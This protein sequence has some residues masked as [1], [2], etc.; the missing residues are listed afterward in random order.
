MI[1]FI[2]DNQQGLDPKQSLSVNIKFGK[3]KQ[4]IIHKYDLV[5]DFVPICHACSLLALSYL[6][7][8]KQVTRKPLLFIVRHDQKQVQTSTQNTLAMTE[9]LDSLEH[10]LACQVCFH[11]FDEDGEHIPR[12]LPCS[13]TL[14][15]SCIKQLIQNSKLE[16]PECRKIHDAE[17]VKTFP[18]NKYILTQL[19]RK[20]P[21]EGSPPK[22]ELCE[23]HKSE[24]ILFCLEGTCQKAICI[25]C[26]NEKHRRHD[27]T[28]IECGQKE[29]QAKTFSIVERNLKNKIAVLSAAKNDVEKK[30]ET[31]KLDLKKRKEEIDKQFAKML[32]EVNQKEKDTKHIIDAEI[33]AVRE[34]ITF[35]LSLKNT[36]EKDDTMTES[37]TMNKFETVMETKENINSNLSGDRNYLFCEYKP[38]EPLS[39]LDGGLRE[40][41]VTVYLPG[42]EEPITSGSAVMRNVIDAS[43][44]GCEGKKL[45][46]LNIGSVSQWQIQGGPRSVHFSGPQF[47]HFHED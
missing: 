28:G 5:L 29:I 21:E 36:A 12:L 37:S 8:S 1:Y 47:L 2:F 11:E 24:L 9:N 45:N 33:E 38:N 6:S 23:E 31:C 35:L 22:V 43:K 39:D 42:I 17:D 40:E 26:L 20:S 30:A 34:N 41:Y 27:V 18:Q 44:L 10:I 19:R 14:C 32:E 16:C 3:V 13:H 7:Q 15:E 25:S 46:L 4:K